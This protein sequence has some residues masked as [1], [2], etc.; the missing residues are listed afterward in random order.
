MSIQK[1]VLHGIKKQKLWIPGQRVCVA[2]SGGVD[3]MV[4]MHILHQTKR[5]HGGVLEVCTIDHQ[6][7]EAS[8]EECAYVVQEA[9]RLNLPV[10]M[11]TLEIPRGGNI[12]ER[13][14]KKR[15]EILQRFDCSVIATGHHQA[16]QAETLLY[17]LLRGSGLDGLSS[18]KPVEN[19]W[20]RPLL[21]ESK[22][23]ILTFAKK[24]EI[25]WF[26]DPSNAK[27]L[28]G[29]LRTIFPIL[30]SIHGASI[31]AIARTATLLNE[32]AVLLA[33][34][35]EQAWL[36]CAEDEGLLMQAWMKEP[37]GMQIR[38][39]RAL[40]LSHN[41]P[42]RAQILIQFQKNPSRA[43]LPKGSWLVCVEGVISI[44]PAKH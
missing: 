36:R 34:Y 10:H 24:Q 18:M 35:T 29:S 2:V 31:P 11:R 9:Q 42:I 3:S 14:R 39:L 13:A 7:R 28:R 27:S 1:R 33:A 44:L 22:E 26:D 17:R 38:L 12:Y 19:G 43:Q 25:R 4:L 23:E 16:D 32:D 40:C 15:Q 6:L 41:V 20:C 37:K 21:N 8:K 5:A 30:D